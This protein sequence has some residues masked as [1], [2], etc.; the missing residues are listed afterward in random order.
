MTTIP[1]PRNPGQNA[2][3]NQTGS[4]WESRVCGV[5]LGISFLT[6]I[7]TLHITTPTCLQGAQKRFSFRITRTVAC[8]GRNTQ[9]SRFSELLSYTTQ[10]MC[11]TSIK[12]KIENIYTLFQ[13][14]VQTCLNHVTWPSI[15]LRHHRWFPPEI[16]LCQRRFRADPVHAGLGGRLTL[17]LPGFFF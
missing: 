2:R 13:E 6:R 11:Y 7:K 1:R 3:K 12:H 9:I 5:F 16:A 15:P 4:C 10:N 14:L 8:A 17:K